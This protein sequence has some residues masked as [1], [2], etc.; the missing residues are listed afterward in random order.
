LGATMRG[1]RR[2]ELGW[3]HGRISRGARYFLPAQPGKAVETIVTLHDGLH[4]Q[5]GFFCLERAEDAFRHLG[6]GEA[7]GGLG[8]VGGGMI[9]QD[10]GYA[11][12]Q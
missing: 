11:D 7:Q 2:S 8:L 6:R 3:L 1:I 4:R 10:V 5:G 9:H 12:P